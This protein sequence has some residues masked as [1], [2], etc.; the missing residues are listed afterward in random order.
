MCSQ[1]LGIPYRP[2]AVRAPFLATL[3]EREVAQWRIHAGTIALEYLE[4]S[5]QEAAETYFE[6]LAVLNIVELKV[7]L[8]LG[9]ILTQARSA[10]EILAYALQLRE[11]SEARAFREWSAGL[12]AA[13][14]DGNRK[15][16]ARYIRELNGVAHHVNRRLGIAPPES[17]T[18]SLGY[19]PVSVSK[20]FHLPTFTAVQPRLKAH[21]WLMQNLYR[22]V[23]EHSRFSQ[24]VEQ[25]LLTKLPDWLQNALAESPIRWGEVGWHQ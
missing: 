17:A 4:M 14:A 3:L 20:A 2:S 11:L 13:V 7:P 9:S 18:L 8:V 24:L 1:A 23:A 5:A 10:D 6:K 25:I 15:V 16:I 12:A 21:A 19:G 22:T